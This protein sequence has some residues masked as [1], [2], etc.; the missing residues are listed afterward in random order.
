MLVLAVAWG[1]LENRDDVI[2]RAVT[3][4]PGDAESGASFGTEFSFDATTIGTNRSSHT[5]TF[6]M[7]NSY[8]IIE[9]VSEESEQ[10]EKEEHGKV[11]PCE[12]CVA[13]RS[14]GACILMQAQTCEVVAALHDRR[15]GVHGVGQLDDDRPPLASLALLGEGGRF[16]HYSRVLVVP[17]RSQLP[18]G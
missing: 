4:Y 8:E 3:Y 7:G 5:R 13:V 11:N 12:V 1:N 10:E 15:R 14:S 6:S 18:S 2:S 9:T 17:L 16:R